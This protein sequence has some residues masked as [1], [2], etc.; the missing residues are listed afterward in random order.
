MYGSQISE[1]GFVRF[2]VGFM[3]MSMEHWWNDTDRAKQKHTENISPCD[4]FSATK[5]ILTFLEPK[6]RLHVKSPVTNSSFW[7][8][9]FSV[10][11]PYLFLCHDYPAF[12]LFSLL[13][14]HNTNIHAPGGI[15]FV[16]SCTLFVLHRYLF[17]S[18][19]FPEFCLL[20]LLITHNTNIHAPTEFKPKTPASDRPQTIALDRSTNAIGSLSCDT[21]FEAQSLSK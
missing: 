12:C 7:I 9:L 16:F 14:T 17:I 3:K 21:A 19:D 1:K 8:L 10:L 20:S 4:K 18:L 11:L 2:S 13:I 5:I 6:S 15:F